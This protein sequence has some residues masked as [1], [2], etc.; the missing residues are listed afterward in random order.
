M[1]LALNEKN[2]A[3]IT[4]MYKKLTRL[5]KGKPSPKFFDYEN[6]AGGTTSLDDFKGKYVYI[7]VWATWCSPCRAEIPHL[8]KVEKQY[9]DK[10]IVFVSI[11]IDKEKQKKAWR[12]MI[13]DKNMGGVQLL[14]KDKKFMDEYVVLGIPRFIL[15]DPE[16]KIV[17]QEAPRPSDPKLIELFKE[18]EI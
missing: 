7:D 14:A 1:A 10:N 3:E 2:K 16:G 6:Y 12:K 13:A 4:E 11:S 5:D 15:I 9:H 8:E 18:Q 17:D